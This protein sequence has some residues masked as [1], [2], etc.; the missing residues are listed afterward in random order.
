MKHTRIVA[1]ALVLTVLLASC[2]RPKDDSD[3]GTKE[4]NQLIE[5]HKQMDNA[6]EEI[7]RP[8]PQEEELK[9]KSARLAE[10]DS[11]LN[12]DK[13]ENETLDGEID[14]EQPEPIK[15]REEQER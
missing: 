10:L 15:R 7:D 4:E 8:F 14:D 2:T 6:R 5:I 3:H 12:M 1:I 9:T 11:M 13:H